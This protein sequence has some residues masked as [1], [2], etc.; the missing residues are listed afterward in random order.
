MSVISR[1]LRSTPVH[2]ATDT[3]KALALLLAPDQSSDAHQELMAVSGT[4]CSQISSESMKDAAV[5]CDGKGPRIRIYCLYDE[6]AI[7]GEDQNEAPLQ[8]C[9]TE[10]DWSV[11]LPCMAEDLDW[12]SKSLK[13]NSSRITAR[14]LAER[15][16]PAEKNTNTSSSA[17]AAVNTE[18]FLRS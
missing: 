4:A 15:L 18:A 7:V 8:T 2:T 3:W 6:N 5:V 1:K 16:G 17:A 13:T 14:N 12:V 9:P 10:E 11:S